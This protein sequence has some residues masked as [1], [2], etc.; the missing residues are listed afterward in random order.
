MRD[1]YKDIIN[2]PNPKSSKHPHMARS[3][4]AAQFSPFAALTGHDDAIN[5]ASRVRD[6]R[7]ELAEDIKAKLNEKLLMVQ[8]SI[9]D[10][11]K[12]SFL[13]FKEGDIKDKGTYIRHIGHVKVI[14][15]YKG[16]IVMVNGTEILVNDIIEIEIK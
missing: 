13:Y 12:V 10:Q 1:S 15:E 7:M 5:E 9:K 6:R 14:D 11:P 3:K 8:E 4:R 16:L 2:L